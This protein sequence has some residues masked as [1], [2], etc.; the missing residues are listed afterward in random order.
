[1]SKYC[2]VQDD[3]SHWY[4]IPVEHAEDFDEWV[5]NEDDWDTPEY[6]EEVGGSP[7]LVEFSVYEIT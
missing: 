4:V 1:M 6:A 7:S 3:S 2:L 5:Q